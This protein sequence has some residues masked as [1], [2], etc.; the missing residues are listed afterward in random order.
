MVDERKLAKKMDLAL[1]TLRNWRFLGKGPKYF[2]F[3]RAVRYGIN[4]IQ[5][6][7]NKHK[8]DPEK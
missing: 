2:K 4:D 8:I 1:Q 5:D 3:G 6:Y 7:I